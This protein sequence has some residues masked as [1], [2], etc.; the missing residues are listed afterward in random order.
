MIL[1]IE[2]VLDAG[3]HGLLDDGR[4]ADAHIDIPN[5]STATTQPKYVLAIL[6]PT[7]LINAFII[8]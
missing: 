6:S 7:I 8:R 4:S 5:Q 3:S 2:R 1:E